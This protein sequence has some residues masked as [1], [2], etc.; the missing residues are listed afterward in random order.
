M[1]FGSP[2]MVVAGPTK[3]GCSTSPRE[4]F[5]RQNPKKPS[6]SGIR[7]VAGMTKATTDAMAKNP[8]STR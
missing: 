2:P 1:R 6:G 3:W 4:T 5:H 7:P 8:S